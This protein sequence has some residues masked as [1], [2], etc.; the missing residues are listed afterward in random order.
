MNIGPV[1]KVIAE[2]KKIGKPSALKLGEKLNWLAEELEIFVAE[3]K[4]FDELLDTVHIKHRD[5]ERELKEVFAMV[6]KK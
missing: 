3:W 2:L 1:E 6:E 5:F 4:E